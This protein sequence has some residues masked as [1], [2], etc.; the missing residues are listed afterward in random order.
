M[1]TLLMQRLEPLN[2][3][4]PELLARC[5]AEAG[6]PLDCDTSLGMLFAPASHRC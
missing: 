2:E 4:R 1:K 3:Q 6:G 5:E